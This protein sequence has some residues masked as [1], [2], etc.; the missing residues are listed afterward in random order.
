MFIRKIDDLL[1]ACVLM[2]PIRERRGEGQQHLNPNSITS[3]LM[4]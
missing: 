3:M 2:K 1:R 4:V